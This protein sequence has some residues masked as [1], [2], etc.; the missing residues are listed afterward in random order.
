[1]ATTKN[2][3]LKNPA[4]LKYLSYKCVTRTSL[5]KIYI[6]I[7]SKAKVFGN[8]DESR[9]IHN[10]VHELLHRKLEIEP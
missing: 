1:M 5:E 7:E 3:P 4:S 9:K 6:F 10:L 8:T 2:T